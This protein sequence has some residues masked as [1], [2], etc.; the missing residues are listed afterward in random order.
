MSKYYQKRVA[1]QEATH[2]TNSKKNPVYPGL[3]KWFNIGNKKQKHLQRRLTSF[4]V[5]KRD[6]ELRRTPQKMKFSI[7]DFFGKCDQ[8]RSFQWI[9]SHLLKKPL[10]GNFIFSAVA[11]IRLNE[12]F[13]ILFPYWS[14]HW[15]EYLIS[16]SRYDKC[17]TK[18]D[19]FFEY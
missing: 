1:T 13:S 7:K 11:I 3:W 12:T 16:Y 15:S 8:S 6:T 10:M 18:C 17:T 2:L 5:K 19:F 14:Y 4:T 9:W